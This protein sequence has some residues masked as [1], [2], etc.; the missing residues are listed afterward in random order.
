MKSLS[1]ILARYLFHAVLLLVLTLFLNMFLYVICG[2]HLIRSTN[3]STSDIRKISGE[4]GRTEE[5]VTLSDQGYEYLEADYVWA[6]LLDDDGTV[7]WNWNLP[8]NLNHPYTVSETASFSKWYLDDYPVTEW[9][10]E[11]GLLVIAQPRGSVWK[12]NI[13]EREKVI[14]YI[15][16]MIPTTLSFNLILVFIVMLV[17]G[18]RFYRSLRVLAVGLEHLSEE[19]AVHLPEKGMTEL[20]ARQLNRTSDILTRQREFLAKREEARTSWIN[21]VS[22]DIRTPLS[23]IMGYAAGL[24]EDASLSD[25]QRH[26]A[27]V[28]EAQSLKIKRLIEDLNL[29]S[30]LEYDMQPLRPAQIHPSRLLRT[31]VSDFYNQGLSDRHLIDF[32]MDPDVEQVTLNGDASLLTR[33]FSNLIHNSIRHNPDGC[34]VTVTAYPDRNGVCFQISDD[35]RGIPDTVIQALE[36]RLPETEKAPHIMGLRIVY[37]IFQAHG[38]QMIFSDSHTIHILG[39]DREKNQ[40]RLSQKNADQ[41]GCRKNC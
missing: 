24:K 6:M 41:Y 30:R 33:A 17:L 28:M 14:R 3:H 8:D 39:T 22:H 4:L 20:L 10:T 21:G 35:G 15:A 2:F 18:F 9:T 12:Y 7:L 40:S 26:L 19:K 5:T 37:Q 29:T 36:N 27:E 23:L 1:K 34:T 38:W 32:Y 16:W 13:K 25:T 11:H 31:V